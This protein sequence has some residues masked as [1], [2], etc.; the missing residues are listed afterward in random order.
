MGIRK[1]LKVAPLAVLLPISALTL[2]TGLSGCTGQD[3]AWIQ[4]EKARFIVG[5]AGLIDA[6]ARQKL[7][8]HPD[9][10]IT[11]EDFISEHYK[12]AAAEGLKAYYSQTTLAAQINREN[13][14]RGQVDVSD[15]D[16]SKNMYP[17]IFVIFENKKMPLNRF[18]SET[19]GRFAQNYPHQEPRVFTSSSYIYHGDTQPLEPAVELHICREALC[20]IPAKVSLS[21]LTAH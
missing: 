12:A 17:E 1:V 20:V 7:L 3:H 4:M 21:A 9:V 13:T 15:F 16:R 2:T 5:N 10:D 8:E 6:F 18:P 19:D 11:A 14:Y